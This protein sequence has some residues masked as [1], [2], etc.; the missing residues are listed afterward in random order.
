MDKFNSVLGICS[1]LG[2]SGYN[3]HARG[4]FTALNKKLPV[5]IK[6]WSGDPNPYYLTNEQKAMMAAGTNGSHTPSISICLHETNHADWNQAFNSPK[7]AYNVWESTLQPESFFNRLLDFDQIWV[8]SN[9]QRNCTIEQGAPA[10]KVFVIP[11]GIDTNRFKLL[12]TPTNCKFAD[13]EKFTF[14]VVGRWEYRKATTE[15]IKSF[16]DAFESFGQVELLLLVD[17]PY[18]PKHRTTEQRLEEEG[19]KDERIKVIHKVSEEE[20]LQLIA[21]TDCFVSCSRAE[22]WN[23]P[24]MEF[25]ACGIPSI[26]SNWS[27]QLE[28]AKDFAY[29]V[30]IKELKP[31]WSEFGSFPGNYAEPD[32]EHLKS[33]MSQ[34]YM[35]YL[36]AFSK[37]KDGAAEGAKYISSFTWENA[38]DTAVEALAPLNGPVVKEPESVRDSKIR[39]KDIFVLDCWLNSEKKI[40]KLD[41]TVDLL[42]KYNKPIAI[43]AHCPLPEQIL[44]KVDYFFYDA[45]NT[46]PEFRLPIYYRFDDLQLHGVLDRPYHSLPIVKTIQNAC[47]SFNH[48]DRIHFLEY[49]INLDIDKHLENV[50][51]H[52]DKEFVCYNY[53]GTGIY[54]SIL[55]FRPSSMLEILSNKIYDWEE[56]RK[57]ISPIIA[58]QDLIFENW[59]F[60]V[61]NKAGKSVSVLNSSI[62]DMQQD[63][64]KEMSSLYYVLS[65]V[66]KGYALFIVHRGDSLR[67]YKVTIDNKRRIQ[68][69]DCTRYSYNFLER[70]I[71]FIEIKKTCS[72]GKIVS[73]IIDVEKEPKGEFIFF[74][75]KEKVTCTSLKSLKKKKYNIQIKNYFVDGAFVEITGPDPEPTF[76]VTFT[77]RVSG[78]VVHSS[79]LKS[80]HWTRTNRTY[81]TDWNTRI[82]CG[83]DE[84]YNMDLSLFQ[85]RVMIVIDSR[86]M[87]DTLAWLPMV[88]AFRRKN[89][90]EVICVTYWNSFFRE[91]YP[92]ITFVE[93]GEVV[94][95]I[96]AK[97]TIGCRDNDLSFNKFNWRITPLQKVAADI[98]GVD[99]VEELPKISYNVK[100]RPITDK[101]VA[102]SEHSTFLAKYWLNEGGWD[103]V[104]EYLNSLGYKVLAISKEPTQLK[105]VIDY[106]NRP[107]EESLNTIHHADLFIGMS[108]GPSW[109]AWALKKPMVLIS[110]YSTKWAEM[111]YNNPLVERVINEKVCHGC[112]ND[113]SLNL[114]R[115][116]WRWCPRRRDFECTRLI[117]PEMVIESIN[118]LL[119]K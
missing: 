23:L 96:F 78:Q 15:I 70:D 63:S 3:Y 90:A 38:A 106:T 81:F 14:T 25:M 76:K 45:D 28:F 2:T 49:D 11:E 24:L 8:P 80:N 111:D 19:I 21:E 83:D 48:Y 67:D 86:A 103:T 54:T 47:R 40:Q 65:E 31:A 72:D 42:S 105:G 61:I 88:E 18:D 17:N 13:P 6:N 71:K 58:E 51:H 98:L 73:T 1:F 4:F 104:I 84:I 68:L 117:T 36:V 34:I 107:I 41:E 69:K 59:M 109:L 33:V 99:Y 89:D 95:N 43:V 82:T 64:F 108:S 91:T 12:E 10:D 20:Y 52:K 97:Y 100:E 57:K 114:E 102:V 27:G 53:E 29:L 22:G 74:G 39:S 60:K 5:R 26:C 118:R 56:Y 112:F 66:E 94:P 32:F 77:D 75:N 46:L 119:K 35:D 7:I 113:P 116:D 92:E 55:S 44:S 85:R 37:V 16:L 93:P 101:Y 87:G 50:N 62:V 9:W 79:T 30:N 115:G 110:G